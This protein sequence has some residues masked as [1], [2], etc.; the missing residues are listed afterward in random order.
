[1]LEH[2]L[3]YLEAQASKNKVR[4]DA[5]L[6]L[7]YSLDPSLKPSPAGSKI[8]AATVKEIAK[9]WKRHTTSDKAYDILILNANGRRDIAAKVLESL[10]QYAVTEPDRGMCFPSVT[11][12]RAYATIIQA[13]AAMDAPVDELDEMRQWLIVRQQAIEDLGAYNPEYIISAILLSGTPWLGTGVDSHVTIDGKTFVPGSIE[14][15]TG[16]FSSRIPAVAGSVV[17]VQPNGVTP[18][19]GSVTS[20]SP[21]PILGIEADGT[22]DLSITKTMLTQAPDGT[23]REAS[24]EL[25]QGDKVRVQLVIHAGRD[26][27]YLTLT[28]ER[29]AALDPVDQLPRTIWQEGVMFYLEPRDTYTAIFPGYLRRGTYI[30]TYDTTVGM[31]GSFVSGIATIQSQRAPEIVAHS[32]GRRFVVGG[33]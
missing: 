27:E 4:T 29:P 18:S 22:A 14:A 11:D 12:I 1:M 17:T 31:T 7:I 13:F 8:L 28:D 10:R 19:Y 26:L 9:D 2:A 20:V 16:Y 23:W 24:D 15:A 5:D 6:A 21:A 25:R 30:L 3:R 32:A 33:K